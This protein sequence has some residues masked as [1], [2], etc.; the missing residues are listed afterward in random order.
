MHKITPFVDRKDFLVDVIG[1]HGWNETQSA[2]YHSGQIARF[3]RHPIQAPHDTT[4]TFM[5][6]LQPS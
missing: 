6:T 1:K 3:Y 4:V 2:L 5:M